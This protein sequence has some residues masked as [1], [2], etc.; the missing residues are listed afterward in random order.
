MVDLLRNLRFN[1]LFICVIVDHV[2][3]DDGDEIGNDLSPD[4]TIK[5]E[6]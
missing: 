6:E 5:T 1:K 2:G 4:K 3:D